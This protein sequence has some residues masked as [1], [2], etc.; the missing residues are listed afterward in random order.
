[1]QLSSL[2]QLC[3]CA[4]CWL[5]K[6]LQLNNQQRKWRVCSLPSL[7]AAQDP[8]PVVHLGEMEP[9]PLSSG[10]SWLV[11]H[12]QAPVGTRTGPPGLFAEHRRAVVGNQEGGS[13]GGPAG[14][15]LLHQLQPL[16]RPWP[17]PPQ[18]TAHT[19]HTASFHQS[20]LLGT[21]SRLW[22]CTKLPR[23]QPGQ[24]PA[25][26]FGLALGSQMLR[27]DV[28]RVGGDLKEKI[29][30]FLRTDG[31][32]FGWSRFSWVE[33]Y[34]PK[35]LLKNF[36]RPSV[37]VMRPFGQHCFIAPASRRETMY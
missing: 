26:I 9:S 17:P 33:C 35:N 14:L 5:Y 25:C 30:V 12:R 23:N 15:L 3:S 11:F 36:R 1:M 10:L 8:V 37:Q 24:F 27:G 32:W 29:S 20:R 31:R 28:G 22:W 6:A 34:F 4:G 21:D 13:V 19:T 16:P 7:R 18:L 2:G